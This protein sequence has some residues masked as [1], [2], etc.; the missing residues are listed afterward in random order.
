MLEFLGLIGIA[1]LFCLIIIFISKNYKQ[2]YNVKSF[3]LLNGIETA[4]VEEIV[5]IFPDF[6]KKEKFDIVIEIGTHLGGLSCWLYEQSKIFEFQFSSY[7]IEDKLDMVRSIYNKIPFDFRMMS[8]LENLGKEEIETIL[9]SN[10]KCLLMCDGGNKIKEFNLY[11]PKLKPKDFIMTHDYAPD[12][13]YFKN[14]INGKIWNWFETYDDA[15]DI[16][17]NNL[18]KMYSNIF[19]PVVWSC[20]KKR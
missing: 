4:Q 14:H 6:F 13:D 11:A 12:K 16:E 20:F 18:E 5:N 17:L 9:L 7:D 19:T 2:K 15:L 10:E 3:F 8:A 1:G